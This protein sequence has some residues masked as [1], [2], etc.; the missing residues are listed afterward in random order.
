MRRGAYSAFFT[1]RRVALLS[2]LTVAAQAMGVQ[3]CTWEKADTAPWY[4]AIG[5]NGENVN[6]KIHLTAKAD[7]LPEGQTSKTAE[8]P[9]TILLKRNNRKNLSVI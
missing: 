2:V 1:R 6:Y 5:A 3:S 8:I 7:Y 4:V 9:G